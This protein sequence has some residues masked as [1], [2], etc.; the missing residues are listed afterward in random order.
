MEIDLTGITLKNFK[1]EDSFYFDIGFAIKEEE[2]S[3]T[4]GSIQAT[5]IRSKGFED[6]I[7][8]ATND[9]VP[10]QRAIGGPS[11]YSKLKKNLKPIVQEVATNL[12]LS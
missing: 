3:R 8:F 5:I 4:L 9:P 12:H 6:G 10:L 7:T 11:R 2:E 1:S